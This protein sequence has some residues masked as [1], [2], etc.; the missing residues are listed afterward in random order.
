MAHVFIWVF[1]VIAVVP[2]GYV[3]RTF[4]RLPGKA[5]AAPVSSRG[6]VGAPAS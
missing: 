3:W 6:G 4:V 5:S 2:W 1:V